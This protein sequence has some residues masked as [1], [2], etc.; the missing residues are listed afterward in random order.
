MLL[1]FYLG[2][3][4][5]KKIKTNLGWQEEKDGLERPISEEGYY[6]SE[7]NF[8]LFLSSV[9]SYYFITEN[10]IQMLY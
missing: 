3:K 4:N 6:F 2:K 7:L 8:H 1:N 9:L 5:N 10:I